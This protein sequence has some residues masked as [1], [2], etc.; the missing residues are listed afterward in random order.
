MMD[1]EDRPVLVELRELADNLTHIANRLV[2]TADRIE[3]KAEEGQT[4]GDDKAG[5]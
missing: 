3:E 2:A 1:V 5:G 4:D